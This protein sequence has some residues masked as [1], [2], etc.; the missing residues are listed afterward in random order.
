VHRGGEMI[1]TADSDN[2]L[3]GSLLRLEQARDLRGCV[4]DELL[5]GSSQM[6]LIEIAGFVN[7][8]LDRNALF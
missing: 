3:N 8:I 6:G 1:D 7:S 4:P 2:A 5:Q